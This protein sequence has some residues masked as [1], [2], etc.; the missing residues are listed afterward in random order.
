MMNWDRVK[1]LARMECA[2]H[3]KFMKEFRKK[4]TRSSSNWRFGGGCAPAHPEN[5]RNPVGGKYYRVRIPERRSRGGQ[6]YGVY[7]GYCN[8]R[9]NDVM[10]E[11][12][13]KD[14]KAELRSKQDKC[15]GMESSP[16][17]MALKHLSSGD[18]K[19]LE[20][21]L[22]KVQDAEKKIGVKP[23]VSA[24]SRCDRSERSEASRAKTF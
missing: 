6:K 8:S 24:A 5:I 9:V 22:F 18:I 17:E 15:R 12:Q 21:S 10:G 2:A 16:L 19:N 20:I 23:V 3:K 1:K 7:W 14:V 11:I 4:R 13:I